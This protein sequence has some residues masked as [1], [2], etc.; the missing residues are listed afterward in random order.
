[1]SESLTEGSQGPFLS[2][3]TANPVT[4]LV[5]GSNEPATTISSEETQVTTPT[6]YSDLKLS[7]PT[8]HQRLTEISDWHCLPFDEFTSLDSFMNAYECIKREEQEDDWEDQQC[9]RIYNKSNKKYRNQ[10]KT[11]ECLRNDYGDNPI[12]MIKYW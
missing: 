8:Q 12:N 7:D 1:M 4:L 11:L 2:C 3:V 6:W 10:P 5:T 9:L